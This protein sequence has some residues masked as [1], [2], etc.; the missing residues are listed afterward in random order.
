[1]S[2]I[3]YPPLAGTTG[4]ANVKPTINLPFKNS[5]FLSPWVTFSRLGTNGTRFNKL[6][7]LEAMGISTPR[8][9][10]NPDTLNCNGLLIESSATNLLIDS[11]QFNNWTGVATTVTAN[12]ATA[13]DGTTT[14]DKIIADNTSGLHYVRKSFTGAVST[15]YYLGCS[16]KDAGAGYGWI[17]LGSTGFNLTYVIVNLATGEVTLSNNITASD[18]TVK[19][20]KDGYWRLS[21]AATS[22]AGAGTYQA[23]V[24]ATNDPTNRT[25]TG[26]GVDGIYAADAVVTT[27]PSSEIKTTTTT[28]TRAS[29]LCTVTGTEF[30]S[31][32][33]P[34]ENTVLD[35]FV[36]QANGTS[37]VFDIANVAGTEKLLLQAI[38][39]ALT[40]K[41]NDL[42]P[43][44]I[45]TITTGTRYRVAIAMKKS[46]YAISINGGDVITS[47]TA[48]MPAPTQLTIGTDYAGANAL[49]ST[50]SV[51][52]LYPKRLDNQTL[53]N[54][55]AV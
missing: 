31:R 14:A 6:G 16:V 45:A 28:I 51:I 33:N 1:M 26:N 53:V 54:M 47:N 15:K 19:K 13:P 9:D 17:G 37:T 10:F 21:I 2:H 23:Q 35:E 52:Q 55:S 24:G 46:D 30:S 50:T 41:I 38:N 7:I 20:L 12:A 34:F 3:T 27:T 11:N 39:G 42:D 25:Y 22:L 44:A 49:N 29:E 36:G 32:W 18:Y 40:F 4:L 8:F 5:R 43:I 48:V